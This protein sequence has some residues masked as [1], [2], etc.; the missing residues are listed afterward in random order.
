MEIIQCF[1]V[2]LI[3]TVMHSAFRYNIVM[4]IINTFLHTLFTYFQ[5][6][7][8]I[9]PVFNKNIMTYAYKKRVKYTLATNTLYVIFFV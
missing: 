7:M 3:L 5:V 8:L 6:A 1:A 2:S 9:L 4:Y